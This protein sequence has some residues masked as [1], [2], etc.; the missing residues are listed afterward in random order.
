M[1]SINHLNLFKLSFIYFWMDLA[2]IRSQGVGT[3]AHGL[4]ERVAYFLHLEGDNSEKDEQWYK[5]QRV[6][7]NSARHFPHIIG[8]LVEYHEHLRWRANYEGEH[9]HSK[10]SLEGNWYKAQDHYARLFLDTWEIELR[11]NRN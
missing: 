7:V 1:Q 6:V 8:N 11:G 9:N 2:T 5:A 10:D 3:D 4:V